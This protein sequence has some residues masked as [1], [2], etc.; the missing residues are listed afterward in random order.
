MELCGKVDED[1]FFQDI[2][3]SVADSLS[4]ICD[5]MDL[6]NPIWFESNQEEF[7]RRNK[8]AFLAANFMD[9]LEFDRLEIEMIDRAA[10]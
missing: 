6:E 10:R 5:I 3:V 2:L 7:I 9:A 1:G 4:E 8:T